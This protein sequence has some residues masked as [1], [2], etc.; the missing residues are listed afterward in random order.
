MPSSTVIVG[1]ADH[2]LRDFAP[3]I[4]GVNVI[5][6]A[7]Q[8]RDAPQPV[9]DA[10]SEMRALPKYTM[11]CGCCGEAMVKPKGLAVLRL[12]PSPGIPSMIPVGICK[13]CLDGN[14][15]TDITSKTV[16]TC[17]GV[18]RPSQEWRD[19]FH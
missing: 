3:Y 13:Q 8:L 1:I 12:H 16:L 5:R 9:V 17:V 6:N 10:L 7:K 14:S 15:D 4:Y 19:T 11:R 18:N 2:P